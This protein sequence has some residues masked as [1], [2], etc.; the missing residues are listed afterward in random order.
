MAKTDLEKQQLKKIQEAIRG[1]AQLV[2]DMKNELATFNDQP[3]SYYQAQQPPPQQQHDYLDETPS[4]DHNRGPARPSEGEGDW[5]FEDRRGGGGGAMWMGGGGGGGGPPRRQY[6]G[7]HRRDD[8]GRRGWDNTPC[9]GGSAWDETPPPPP[10]REVRRPPDRDRATELRRAAPKPAEVRG[11]RVS[12]ARDRGSN[13]GGGPPGVEG[14][15]KRKPAVPTFR[16]K[17]DDQG[18]GGK[19]GGKKGYQANTKE[20]QELVDMMEQFIIEHGV[21]VTWESIAGLKEAKKLLEEAV[22]LPLWL[23]NVFKGIRRPWS[24]VLM[25]GPPGTGK[26]LL[27]KA[28]ATECDTTFFNVSTATLTSKWRGESEK[29]VRIL[30]EMARHYSPATIFIDEI[31]A[32]TGQRGGGGEHEASRRVKTELLVQM[33]GMAAAIGDEARV[34]V[35]GATNHPWDLDDAIRRRFEKRIYIPLPEEPDREEL[36]KINLK[37]LHVADGCDFRLLSRKTAGYSGHDITCL[38]R[39][40]S[41]MKLRR[42]VRDKTKEE[43]KQMGK[44]GDM[45][46][47]LPV[48]MQ[49]FEEA[50]RNTPASV[51]AT[52]LTRYSK[53]MEEFG[54]AV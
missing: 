49:D 54:S 39:D 8:D 5:G 31:D 48:S 20:D 22:V 24:G 50:L 38:C 28:V 21:R 37:D 2:G 35:L 29:L 15:Q 3:H 9:A 14:R 7:N 30:F 11:T 46:G 53:W 42:L 18:Q 25:Y 13:Q 45:S 16:K 51:N 4:R 43:I 17:T 27:A 6:G 52:Q 10:A 44:Q 1:E 23:P 33:D 40:A 41:M 32:L 47:D 12:A 26:T 19:G 36:F 34:M